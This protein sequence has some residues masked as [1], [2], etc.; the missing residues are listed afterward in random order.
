M[1]VE[2]ISFEGLF[3]NDSTQLVPYQYNS[4]L[5]L[6]KQIIVS[7][8]SSLKKKSSDRKAQRSR[9]TRIL[10]TCIKWH[11]ETKL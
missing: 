5:A 7:P 11:E 9:K 2:P 1:N 6:G 8:G 3:C 10:E 4:N